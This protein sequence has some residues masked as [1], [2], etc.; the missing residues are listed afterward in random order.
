MKSAPFKKTNESRAGLCNL[1]A[2]PQVTNALHSEREGQERA[3][4]VGGR[5]G[6]GNDADVV[7]IEKTQIVLDYWVDAP[8]AVTV[9]A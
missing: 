5:L 4:E 9:N 1:L 3:G 6:H 7:E 2:V 8:V